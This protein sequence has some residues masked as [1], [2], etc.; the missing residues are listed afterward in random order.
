MCVAWFTGKVESFAVNVV[1]DV[2][3]L[4]TKWSA[5]SAITM[6]HNK[7]PSTQYHTGGPVTEQ[8]T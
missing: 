7:G 1:F 5:V 2:A 4:S 6:R 8:Q 3:M